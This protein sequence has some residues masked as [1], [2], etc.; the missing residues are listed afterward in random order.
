VTR[1]RQS[2]AA[3]RDILA[4]PDLRR[5]QIA[6]F[7]GHIAGW[8]YWIVV[9]LYAYGHG[10]AIAVGVVGGLRLGGSALAA[11]F[12]G[13]VADR[14]PRR[15]VLVATDVVRAVLL[16]IA[17]AVDAA[18]GPREVVIGL[19]VLFALASTAFRPALS[20]LVPTLA[21][22]PED[23][24][25]ANVTAS[26]IESVS[27]FVGP[28]LAGLVVAAGGT[29]TGFL[30]A[31]AML[32]F[33]AAMI[34]RIEAREEPRPHE[35]TAQGV[36]QA[37]SDG[38]RAIAGNRSLALLVGLF[39][40]QTFVCGALTVL[41]VLLARQTLGAGAAAVGYLNSAIGVGGIVGSVGSLGLV[42]SRRLATT[43][44]IGVVLWGAPLVVIGIHP[45]LALALAL[46][47]VVG[48]GNTLVDV[49]GFTL[50][51]RAVP[52]QV[53]A[54]VTGAMDSLILASVAAGAFVAPFVVRWA[55]IRWTFVAAGCVLPV[56]VALA[57]RAL[58][59]LDTGPGAQLGERL[60]VVGA[61][62]ILAPLPSVLLERVAH[63]LVEVDLAAGET[64]FEAG[65]HGD[66]FWII[67]G[68][69][70]EIAPPGE[71]PKVLGPGES[72]G[73]IALLRD[74][75]RTATATARAATRLYG[76][77]RDLFVAAV[78]GHAD[79]TAAAE[80]TIVARLESL[81]PSVSAI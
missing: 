70:V 58:R 30:F 42:G 62:P 1:A 17:A 33:S 26:A 68:G 15:N 9:A 32:A 4:S 55:G 8:A 43:F 19:V 10:G 28:T 23:L 63:E 6:G 59:R 12:A 35:E 44:G 69:G 41:T 67:A 49:A 80:A 66:R 16:V 81:R 29:V 57:W 74:V 73:E 48:F 60:R 53:L 38:I 72:F 24:T 5:L 65:D 20:A 18:D 11:P 76:L 3:V 39:T 25:A 77:D 54:R 79:S 13:V 61:V 50:L 52:D 56:T 40:A 51:Q 36:L 14:F 71:E 34:F 22:T 27:L 2:L 31:A 45:A 46:L 37:A 64:L 75:P 47:A 78:T 7:A 21:R